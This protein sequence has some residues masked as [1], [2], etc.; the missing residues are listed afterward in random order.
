MGPLMDI[1]TAR[2]VVR[3]SFRSSAELQRLLGQLKERCSPEEYQDYARG[4]AAAVDAIG[5]G[6]V[7]KTI[8]AHPELSSEIEAS[9]TKCGRFA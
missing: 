5:V 9:I 3:A 7:N 1:E 2:E 8:A 4:I 6:L